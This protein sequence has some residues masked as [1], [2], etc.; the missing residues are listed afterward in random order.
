MINALL[1]DDHTIFRAGLVRLLEEERTIGSVTQA[2]DGTTA[3]KLIREQPFHVVLLDINLPVRSGLE[4]IAPIHR[5]APQLPV[6]ILSMY[7]AKQYAM[8]A[9][10]AGAKGYVSKDM[11]AEILVDAI[12]K[13]VQGGRYITPEVAETML[14]NI[15]ALQGEDRHLKLSEREYSVMI[16]IAGGTSLTA[17]AQD[18]HVSVKTI[19]TYRSRLLKKMGLEG[20]AALIQYAIRN[21]LID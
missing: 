14:D 12:H 18:M 20:N 5:I 13:V 17:M 3:L 11:D 8:R 19:S 9:Y 16:Q 4:L 10:E 6:I 7:S 1:V 15:D 2:A 21:R